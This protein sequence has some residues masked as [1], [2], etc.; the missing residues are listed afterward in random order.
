MSK[1]TEKE[2]TLL[3]DLLNY[4]ES[5]WKKA[6]LYGSTITDKDLANAFNELSE[7]HFRRFSKLVDLL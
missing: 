2:M 3:T 1:L 6:K 7:S 4:E 5:A